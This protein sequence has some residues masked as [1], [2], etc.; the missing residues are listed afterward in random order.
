[1]P[2]FTRVSGTYKNANVHVRSA[3]TYV[4][5]YQ[6]YTKTGGGGGNL[7]GRTPGRLVIG[8]HVLSHVEEARRH[9]Q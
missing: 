8:G 1:M 7:F 3:G 2:L 9:G 4:P 6:V 5:V